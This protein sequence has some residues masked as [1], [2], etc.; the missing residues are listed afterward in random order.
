MMMMTMT[1]KESSESVLTMMIILRWQWVMID[2]QKSFDSKLFNVFF[3]LRV[4]DKFIYIK[5]HIHWIVNRIELYYHISI[6]S[7]THTLTYS[8]TANVKLQIQMQIIKP[9]INQP[10]WKNNKN[11]MIINIKMNIMNIMKK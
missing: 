6:N 9:T 3:L 2:W 4:K 7:L 1:M 5:I 11:N 8:L 10:N